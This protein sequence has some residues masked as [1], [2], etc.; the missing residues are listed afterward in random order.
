LLNSR[1]AEY[2]VVGGNA[3]AFLGYPRTT[4]DLDIWIPANRAN[5]GKI[6]DTLLEFGFEAD[7][8]DETLLYE[9]DKV[10]RM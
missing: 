6:R 4:G 10:I 7:Q 9:K 1:K 3:L 8:L 2:L 5:P